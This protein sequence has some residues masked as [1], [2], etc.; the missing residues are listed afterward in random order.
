MIQHHFLSLI[1]I[2]PLMYLFVNTRKIKMDSHRCFYPIALFLQIFPSGRLLV[3]SASLTGSNWSCAAACFGCDLTQLQW[4][5]DGCRWVNGGC[6]HVSILVWLRDCL[7]WAVSQWVDQ[8][9][10]QG[11][12]MKENDTAAVTT[13]IMYVAMY[14]QTLQLFLTLQ[15]PLILWIWNWIVAHNFNA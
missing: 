4:L 15:F 5:G 7:S 10:E 12:S 8:R 11:R 9:D 13:A 3:T 6:G 2:L 14:L 1:Q